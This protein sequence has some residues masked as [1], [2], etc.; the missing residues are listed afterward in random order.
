MIYC[1]T[2]V[3]KFLLKILVSGLVLLH[4]VGTWLSQL[5]ACAIVLSKTH[6]KTPFSFLCLCY[7]ITVA[8]VEIIEFQI[9][10]QGIVFSRFFCRFYTMPHDLRGVE[11]HVLLSLICIYFAVN[12][13]LITSWV[14]QPMLL[15]R[16]EAK[17]RPMFKLSTSNNLRQLGKVSLVLWCISCHLKFS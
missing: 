7:L 10:V 13:L 9:R 4:H 15:A 5:R 6:R 11:I 16:V 17:S 12:K 1:Q 2:T 8:I 14:H 3:R